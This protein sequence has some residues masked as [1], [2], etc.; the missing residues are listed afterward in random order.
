MRHDNEYGTKEKEEE[1]RG[2]YIEEFSR[3]FTIQGA[4]RGTFSTPPSP[5]HTE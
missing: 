3:L 2:L 5:S 1:K 4:K